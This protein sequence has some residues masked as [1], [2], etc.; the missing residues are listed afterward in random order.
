MGRPSF[1][2]QTNLKAR[3][4]DLA[5]IVTQQTG[6][7]HFLYLRPAPRPS[8]TPRCRG[9]GQS[10]ECCLTASGDTRCLKTP[11]PQLWLLQSPWRASGVRSAYWRPKFRLE[12][13]EPQEKLEVGRGRCWGRRRR[14]GMWKAK[15]KGQRCYFPRPLA[16]STHSPRLSSP[17]LPGGYHWGRDSSSRA[18]Q[19]TRRAPAVR[20]SRQWLSR[21]WGLGGPL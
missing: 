3:S 20:V 19:V 16:Q 12:A 6:C 10:P 9:V 2:K 13:A 7:A 1:P 8:P 15:K 4:Q 5:F 21:G 14:P 17:L 18:R 11:A